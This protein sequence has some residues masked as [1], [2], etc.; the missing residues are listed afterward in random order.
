MTMAVTAPSISP[1]PAPVSGSQATVAEVS[2]DDTPPPGW[3]QWGSLPT[4]ALEPPVGVLV[5]RDDGCVMSGH[6]EDGAEASLSHAAPPA[7][8]GITARPEQ[9][10][11]RVGAAP[12]NFSEGQAEQALW[13][14]LHGH[15]ASLNQAQNEALRIHSG[16]A[17]RVFQVRDCSSS[18]VVL[19]LSF[20]PRPRFP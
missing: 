13:D 14:K 15:S 6:P 10:R 1:A 5:M 17:W 12:A 20:L 9:E 19:P 11:E 4:P 3:D 8:S 2:D 7:S 16:P 18:L